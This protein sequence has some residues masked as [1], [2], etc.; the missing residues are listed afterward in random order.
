MAAK[1]VCWFGI[2]EDDLVRVFGN[3]QEDVT[4]WMNNNPNFVKQQDIGRQPPVSLPGS[5]ED[6]PEA[7]EIIELPN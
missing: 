3:D 7:P 2:T 4:N 1:T 6:L 5:L